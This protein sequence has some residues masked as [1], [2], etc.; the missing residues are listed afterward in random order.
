M[1]N[2]VTR[3]SLLS[4]VSG[5]CI[6]SDKGA[7]LYELKVPNLEGRYFDSIVANEKHLNGELN[8]QMKSTVPGT[9]DIDVMSG[10]EV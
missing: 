6:H 2:K 4:P 5:H 3:N 10:G 9:K 7:A 8:D 1:A